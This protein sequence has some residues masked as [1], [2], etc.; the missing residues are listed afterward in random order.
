M[1]VFRSADGV[2]WRFLSVL[3]DAR[4]YPQSY[5]GP[6][7]HDITYLPDRKTLLAVVW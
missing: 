6:N 4:D 1:V 7:E 2:R 5:E 3:A